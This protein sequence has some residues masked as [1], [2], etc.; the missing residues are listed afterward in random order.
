MANEVK[1][2]ALDFARTT[3][4]PRVY[5]TLP[6]NI[7]WQT[8]FPKKMDVVGNFLIDD[9]Y[10]STAPYEKVPTGTGMVVWLPNRGVNSVGRYGFVPAG[11][12][13]ANNTKGLALWANIPPDL[14]N[15]LSL[16]YSYSVA[17]PYGF[18]GNVNDT[19]RIAP[20]VF[21]TFALA[22]VYA[23]DIRVISDTVPIGSTALNGYLSSASITNT[24]DVAQNINTAGGNCFDPN[25]LVQA[26]CTS[27]DSY[28]EIGIAR[29]VIAL[30]G[31]DV[32]P[33]YQ[34]PDYTNFGQYTGLETTFFI[35]GS[36]APP[37]PMT[38]RVQNTIQSI[39]VSP[40]NVTLK[41]SGVTSGYQATNLV[42]PKCPLNGTYK[43]DLNFKLLKPASINY[44]AQYVLQVAHVFATCNG[45]ST[46]NP[47]SVQ[48]FTK[49]ETYQYILQVNDLQSSTANSQY[50]FWQ[51]STY[52]GTSG[53]DGT[54][55]PNGMSAMY[56]GSQIQ[57]S[58]NSFGTQGGASNPWTG[59]GTTSGLGSLS[60]TLLAT[61]PEYYGI[62]EL[63]PARIMRW[64]GIT[65]VRINGAISPQIV[66]V[67]GC[68]QVQVVPQGRLVPFVQ[69]QSMF[70]ASSL[71]LDVLTFVTEL[72][73]GPSPFR[74]MWIGDQ[75]DEFMQS[76]FRQFSP[77]TII[78]WNFQKLI[79]M[80]ARVG[81]FDEVDGIEA[82]AG[83][84]GRY[85]ARKRKSEEGWN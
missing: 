29:G 42:L 8:S 19:V 52:S 58:C 77:S 51:V 36:A 13:S 79:S 83:A 67:D 23:G 28:K 84:G 64:D 39:W 45:A 62:G 22:R 85:N 5:N 18:S 15:S 46:V 11:T 68:V 10:I 59:N 69:A 63:G 41:D 82:V 12:T 71:T 53:L 60:C 21:D 43:F 48:Y 4:N 35:P 40:W 1:T 33:V 24:N 27:K 3:I 50:I 65:S 55:V 7:Y 16:S 26:S 78:N 47:Y 66:K 81:A 49:T 72:Y 75:Y 38:Y 76:T 37:S 20:E 57:L 6:P 2:S 56:I 31:S 34:A 44:D 32:A 61:C 14:A 80:A 25:D 30:V 9:S 70:S 17:V 54:L 73:N 74:R